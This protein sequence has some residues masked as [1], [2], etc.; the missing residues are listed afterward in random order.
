M[1]LGRNLLCES[2]LKWQPAATGPFPGVERAPG[3]PM[4]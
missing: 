1:F 2:R 3:V 4:G